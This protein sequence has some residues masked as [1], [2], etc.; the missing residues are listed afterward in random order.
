VPVWPPAD[1]VAPALMKISSQ[2]SQVPHGVTPP[3]QLRTVPEIPTHSAVGFPAPSVV[4]TVQPPAFGAPGS[5]TV[6]AT[7][8]TPNC[9]WNGP[10][11][12][13]WMIVRRFRPAATTPVPSWKAGVCP[14][15]TTCL[16][17]PRG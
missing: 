2:V 15:R 1:Q 14:D 16:S 13:F 6:P 10:S 12:W 3:A 17:R 7:C 5:Y 8:G 11:S 4:I 9:D